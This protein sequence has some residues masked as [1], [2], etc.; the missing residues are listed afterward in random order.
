MASREHAL[1]RI[2][3]NQ[4]GRAILRDDTASS[5]RPLTRRLAHC[6]DHLVGRLALKSTPRR[7][8]DR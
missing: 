5:P 3:E 6:Y 4:L 2:E 8:R 1:L 7:Y